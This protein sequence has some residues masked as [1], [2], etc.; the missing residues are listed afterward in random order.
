M[1]CQ[2]QRQFDEFYCHRCNLRWDAKDDDPPVCNPKR[3]WSSIEHDLL[4]T[5]REIN[6]EAR[7]N[8]MSRDAVRNIA[9]IAQETLNK[10]EK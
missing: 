8:Q 5:I 10:Y 1:H 4:E 2:A 6:R 7:R 3:P 9:D